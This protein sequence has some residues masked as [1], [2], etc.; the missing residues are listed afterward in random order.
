MKDTEAN[1]MQKSLGFDFVVKSQSDPGGPIFECPACGDEYEP[2]VTYKEDA[3][4]RTP[5]HEQHQTG[6]CS[7]ECWEAYLG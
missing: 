3:E 2:D 1:Q 4:L 5:A 6:I 7:T